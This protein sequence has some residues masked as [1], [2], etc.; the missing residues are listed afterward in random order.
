MRISRFAFIAL[1]CLFIAVP[2]HAEPAAVLLYT[3]NSIGK[4]NPC[5][6]CDEGEPVGGLARR[7]QV[8][9]KYRG[10]IQE[11][12]LF[13]LGGGNE[14][15]PILPVDLPSG[16][17]TQF[18]AKAYA[19]L[20]YDLGLVLPDEERRLKEARA[21]DMPGWKAY[22]E[23][24]GT[25]VL[26]KG[27]LSVGVVLFPALGKDL[28]KMDETVMREV[29]D[30]AG[31]LRG[32]VDLVVGMSPWGEPN[33]KRFLEIHPKALD[34]LF[35][36][37]FGAGSGL[38]RVGESRTAWIRPEFNGWSIQALT[39]LRAPQRGDGGTWDPDRDYAYESVRL[40][41]DVA[42]DDTI[43]ALLRWL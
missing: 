38:R 43:I 30:L 28:V 4:Y 33:E 34:V 12:K 13:I 39:V 5:P 10:Q 40:D 41:A 9:A 23:R 14:F 25:Q 24:P 3:A 18:T 29:A 17:E 32:Q 37:G 1:A 42:E 36:S 6:G 15:L 26:E 7:S 27:G 2:A 31:G 20:D 21:E 16:R 35:G 22:P 19:I 8:F 11:S